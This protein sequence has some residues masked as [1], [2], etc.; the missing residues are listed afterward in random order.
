MKHKLKNNMQQVEP[1]LS[2]TNNQSTKNTSWE[3]SAQDALRIN[4]V[5]S[6]KSLPDNSKRFI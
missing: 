5:T 3:M 6:K 1:K 2:T 4:Y